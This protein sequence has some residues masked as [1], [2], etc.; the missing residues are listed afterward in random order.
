MVALLIFSSTGHLGGYYFC[1][2]AFHSSIT[3]LHSGV[4]FSRFSGLLTHPLLP[5][6]PAFTSAHGPPGAI[7]TAHSFSNFVLLAASSAANALTLKSKNVIKTN[8][9]LIV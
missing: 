5:P 7:I 6:P 4:A 3:A 2:I 9:S 8:D 1:C